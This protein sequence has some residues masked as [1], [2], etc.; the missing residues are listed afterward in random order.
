MKLT[1][2]QHRLLTVAHMFAFMV[3]YI[4]FQNDIIIYVGFVVISAFVFTTGVSTQDRNMDRLLGEIEEL[5]DNKRNKVNLIEGAVRGTPSFKLNELVSIY[6]KKVQEDVKVAG[7]MI[8]LA[9]K[10]HNGHTRCRIKS[11]SSTPY[12]HMLQ[13]T[14][15]TMLDSIDSVTGSAISTLE[16]LSSGNFKAR[17]K[18]NV[19]GSLARM[20]NDINTLGESLEKM[21][22]E[23][24]T[25][26]S[27]LTSNT[28]QLHST[29][30]TMKG[31]T[32]LEL[33]G[34]IDTT[35]ER[36]DT[37]AQKENELADN[38][39]SLV[40]S[41]NETKEILSTIGDIAD[42][43]NLLALNAAIEAARAGEHGRGFAVVAD[44]V[45]KLA[46]RTQKSLAEI[47]ATINVLVQA[48]ADSSETLNLNK[49]DMMD[50]TQYV[51]TVD[52]KM[53]EIILAMDELA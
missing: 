1:T 13:K 14:M 47:S 8:L 40:S 50:L 37:I 33:N 3:L 28:E 18:V 52:T 36:I 20:L 15:N 12:V 49:E 24:E 19:E 32:F 44:E 27:E 51:G 21:E 53:N 34:M 30:D 29:L 6:Q 45:R 11:D 17:V 25:A 35:I 39:Q 9:D 2:L 22:E 46:E 42:Q 43:T 23:N 48:I 10:V 26:K 4:V 7:E 31:T 41:A 16:Q 38:L 5:L